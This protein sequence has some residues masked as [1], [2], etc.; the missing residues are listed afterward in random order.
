MCRFAKYPKRVQIPDTEYNFTQP[1]AISAL[2]TEA[3]VRR[4]SAKKVFLAISRNSQ[5]N[6]S[7]RV[8]FLTKSQ[9]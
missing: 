4:C 1:M 6:T 2:Y 7:A 5:E 9:A 3:V 8:S